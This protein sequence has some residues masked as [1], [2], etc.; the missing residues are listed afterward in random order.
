MA[1]DMVLPESGSTASG[2]DEFATPETGSLSSTSAAAEGSVS[3]RYITVTT[4]VFRLKIDRIGGNVVESS[5]LQYDESLN[6][7]QPLKLL[8]SEER[9]VGK[10]C[11]S[12]RA[13]YP[14]K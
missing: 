2:N 1:D 14:Y 13:S 4:D 9:R 5:L 3:N 10:E 6:S 11:K 12:G 8:R 7:E